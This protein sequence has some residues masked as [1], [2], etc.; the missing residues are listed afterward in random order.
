M[1]RDLALLLNENGKFVDVWTASIL[2]IRWLRKYPGTT[3]TASLLS[4]VYG[5]TAAPDEQIKT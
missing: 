4:T 3:F 5:W 2:G 1:M